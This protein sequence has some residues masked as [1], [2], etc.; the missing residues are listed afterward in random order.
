MGGTI[1]PLHPNTPSWR[2]AQLKN[3]KPFHSRY[4]FYMSVKSG[5]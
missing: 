4:H 1:P 5:Q 3:K 2:G